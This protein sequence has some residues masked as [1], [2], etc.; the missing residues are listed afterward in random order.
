MA[1]C[2]TMQDK[3]NSV[4]SL[5]PEMTRGTIQVHLIEIHISM[6][7]QIVIFIDEPAV[8]QLLTCQ[9]LNHKMI[10]STYMLEPSSSSESSSKLTCHRKRITEPLIPGKYQF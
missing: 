3:L 10:H 1:S 7:Y 6:R 4:L 8:Q 5:V 9:L 2:A